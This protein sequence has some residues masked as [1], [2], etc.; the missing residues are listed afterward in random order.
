MEVLHYFNASSY[1]DKQWQK[2]AT[3]YGHLIQAISLN[4]TT[5]YNY[6]LADTDTTKHFIS[7]SNIQSVNEQVFECLFFQRVD[8]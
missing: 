7:F 2:T 6:T 4:I 8:L 3:V 1:S 5:M